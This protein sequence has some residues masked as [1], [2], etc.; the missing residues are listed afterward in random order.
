MAL[1]IEVSGV[2]SRNLPTGGNVTFGRA[3]DGVWMTR[4]SPDG[5]IMSRHE[6]SYEGYEQLRQQAPDWDLPELKPPEVVAP[7]TQGN[8]NT[9]GRV[10]G[11]TGASKA[12]AQQSNPEV[13]PETAQE[14]GTGTKVL[15]GLQL[16]LDAAGLIPG[17]GEFADLANAGISALRGDFVGAGLSLAAAI[18]FVGWGATGAKATRRTMQVAEGSAKAGREGAEQAGRRGKGGNGKDDGGKSKGNGRDCRLRTYREGCPGGQTPHHV[19]PD[20]V[21]RMPGKGGEYFQG[22]VSHADGYTVCVDGGTPIKKGT[23]ANEHGKIHAIYDPLEAALGLKGNP[24]GTATLGELEALG[25]AAASKITGCNPLRMA[26]ELRA[27]HAKKGMPVSR[28]FRADPYG[29]IARGLDPKTLG[30]GATPTG[31]GGI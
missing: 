21:F 16:G 10:V 12:P 11:E 15:D 23:R 31:R 29:S 18:P 17:V 24:T 22:G 3:A 2:M 27:Y 30:S 8:G 28:K 6:F 25:V 26:A 4:W 20:R 14:S 9:V 5:D 1:E 7:G 19:V 13:E